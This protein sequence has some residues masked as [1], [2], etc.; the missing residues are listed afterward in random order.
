MTTVE[1]STLSLSLRSLTQKPDRATRGPQSMKG[2]I[3]G[4]DPWLFHPG[5]S[6]TTG[7]EELA[8]KAFVLVACVLFLRCIVAVK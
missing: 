5:M 4:T 8:M 1:R 6:L 7:S 3:S 2:E